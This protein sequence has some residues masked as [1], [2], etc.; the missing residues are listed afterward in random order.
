ML[1][2]SGEVGEHVEC[3]VRAFAGGQ[4]LSS[5]V[6][7]TVR[8]IFP[9]HLSWVAAPVG[10]ALAVFVMLVTRTVHPPGA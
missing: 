5:V 3:D 1:I 10:V 4:F 8:Q 7:C 2:S 6:G 9:Q